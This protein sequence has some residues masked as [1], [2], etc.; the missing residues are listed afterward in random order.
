MSFINLDIVSIQQN[1]I[2]MY[3]C[4]MS[5]WYVEQLR[6]VFEEY[7]ERFLVKN[8]FFCFRDFFLLSLVG[9]QKLEKLIL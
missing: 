3:V 6:E 9:V 4:G 7:N 2:F 1:G 8:V 5:K